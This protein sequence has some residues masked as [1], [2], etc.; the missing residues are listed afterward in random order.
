MNDGPH[1]LLNVEGHS[2]HHAVHEPGG[3]VD[4]AGVVLVVGVVVRARHAASSAVATARVVAL[5]GCR[6]SCGSG[7]VRAHM[8]IDFD[9]DL[10][11][12]VICDLLFLH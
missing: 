9:F 6:R 7:G 11:V 12:F 2:G 10:L 8:D 3:L 1:G 4:E 5:V